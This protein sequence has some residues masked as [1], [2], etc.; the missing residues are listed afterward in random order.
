MNTCF[1]CALIEIWD[2]NVCLRMYCISYQKLLKAQKSRINS[3]IQRMSNMRIGKVDSVHRGEGEVGLHSFSNWRWDLSGADADRERRYKLTR[4]A[5]T[6]TRITRSKIQNCGVSTTILLLG[7][8]DW[9]TDWRA[10]WLVLWH[11]LRSLSRRQQ[12]RRRHDGT[13]TCLG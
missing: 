8:T 4:R 7:L 13:T 2:Y 3:V 10:D 6:T 5:T 1:E 12:W 9:M 11:F